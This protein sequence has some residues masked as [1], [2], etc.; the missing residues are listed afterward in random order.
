MN[1]KEPLV[2]HLDL[3]TFKTEKCD[4]SK[5]QSSKKCEFYHQIEEKRRSR[6]VYTPFLCQEKC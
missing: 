4:K 1:E 6:T 3:Q 5:C 2:F